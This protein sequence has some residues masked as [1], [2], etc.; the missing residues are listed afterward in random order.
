[1]ILRAMMSFSLAERMVHSFMSSLHVIIF[2]WVWN[3]LFWGCRFLCLWSWLFPRTWEF[4]SGLGRRIFSYLR[5]RCWW[6]YVFWEYWSRGSRFCYFLRWV[7]SPVPSYPFAV[8]WSI[9]LVFFSC[10]FRVPA[11]SLA[12]R[13]A[14]R[15]QAARWCWSHW[16]TASRNDWSRR[17]PGICCTWATL[18]YF[19]SE[20]TIV[21]LFRLAGYPWSARAARSLLGV[22]PV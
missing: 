3:F 10:I 2:T 1:M 11:P 4:L 18:P 6:F 8:A 9:R 13:S 21:L 15:V 19:F 5:L 14:S 22:P 12:F 20:K 17:N 7:L 16:C